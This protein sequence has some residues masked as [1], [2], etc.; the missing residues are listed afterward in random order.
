MGDVWQNRDRIWGLQLHTPHLDPFLHKNSL[1]N[2]KIPLCPKLLGCWWLKDKLC[3][4]QQWVLGYPHNPTCS[5]L[6][7]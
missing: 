2:L 6:L 1:K 5:Q 7:P 3:P 4:V